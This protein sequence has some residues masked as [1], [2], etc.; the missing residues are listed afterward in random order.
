MILDIHTNG[1]PILRETTKEIL[2]YTNSF[3]NIDNI[4]KLIKN[5]FETMHE[6]NGV[7]LAANQIGFPIS[8]FIVGGIMINNAPFEKVFINPKIINTFGQLKIME[9]GCLSVP[10][11]NKYISR[12]GSL[13]LHYYD[14]NWVKKHEFF[15]DLPARIIQHEYDHLMGILFTDNVTNRKYK[16]N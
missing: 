4:D 1:D 10:G 8:L 14:K 15:H 13:L 11:I 3:E 5:M 7:G 6:K 9:E 2:L 12:P 16:N